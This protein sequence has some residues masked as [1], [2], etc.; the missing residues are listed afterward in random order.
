M[1]AIDDVISAFQTAGWTVASERVG[2]G[3][4]PTRLDLKRGRKQGL[5][6]L[7]YAWKITGEGKGRTGTNFRI[8]TTRT[9]DG[10]LMSED[11]RL[12]I[13]FGID[14]DREVIATFD[15]WT[16]RNTGGSSSVHI[17]R[18]LL[19]DAQANGHAIDGPAWDSRAACRLGDIDQLLPWIDRQV[20]VREAA[21]HPVNFEISGET[22]TA[23]ADLWDSAPPGWLRVGDRLVLTDRQIQHLEDSSIWTI[24]SLD[25]TVTSE[26]G[27]RY[28]R[29]AVSF[30]LQRYGRVKDEAEV[31]AVLLGGKNL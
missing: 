7:A 12:T 28:P 25:V 27:K 2:R 13:G 17:K 8:Q 23:T 15:G 10:P 1:S 22:A 11:H 4:N 9:H 6:L 20:K 30:G 24:K 18:Q 5:S 26:E 14:A 3:P 21:V 16:K 29:R 19:D 31:L